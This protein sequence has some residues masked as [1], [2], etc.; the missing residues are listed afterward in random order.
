MADHPEHTA[1]TGGSSPL[2]FNLVALTPEGDYVLQLYREQV[3]L[4][5]DYWGDTPPADVLDTFWGRARYDA[6]ATYR[7]SNNV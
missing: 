7:D 5:S 1:W 4:W 3:A 2:T 6:H